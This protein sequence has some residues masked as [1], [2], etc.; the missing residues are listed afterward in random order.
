MH[1]PNTAHDDTEPDN[2]KMINDTEYLQE[3][4]VTLEVS[5]LGEVKNAIVVLN[6]LRR[7][8][9]DAMGVDENDTEGG[10]AVLSVEYRVEGDKVIAHVTHGLVD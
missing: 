1:M 5:N 7:Q 3:G 6:K 10:T 8:A 2:V 4:E 9:I